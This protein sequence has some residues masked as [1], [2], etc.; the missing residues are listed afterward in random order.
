LRV[1]ATSTCPR[2]DHQVSRL[3]RPTLRPV[4]T[5]FRSGSPAERVNLAGQVQLV[6]S[7]CKRHAVTESFPLRLVVGTRFQV[8]FTPLFGVLFTFPSRYWSTIGLP[9]VFSLGGWC[10]RI[11]AGFLRSRATQDTAMAMVFACT[12]LSPDTA[13]LPIRFQFIPW[14]NNAVLQPPICRNITGLGFSAFARHYLRNHSCFLLL[15]LLRC[16]SSARSPPK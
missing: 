7:L 12:G 14:Y 3:P 16:F 10:R 1:T 4:R 15:R 9:G 8:L 11:H 5:R 6:G 2:V 13:R